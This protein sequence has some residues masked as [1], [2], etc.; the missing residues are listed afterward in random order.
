MK[1]LLDSHTH[2]LASGH[3]YCTLLEMV[4]AAADRGLELICITDHA[5][6]MELTTHKD[7][8]LNFRVIDREIYGV[9]VMMGAELN[10]MDF[11]GTVD[12][13]PK[14]LNNLD[15]AIASQ[16]IWCMPQGGGP[17]EN[18][19]AMVLAM[20]NCPKICILG[21]PDDGRYPLDY[22]ALVRAA[23]E[24]SVLLEVNNTSL[25]PACSRVNSTANVTEMLKHCRREGVPVVV[26]SDA[27]FVS[28]VG[29]HQYAQALLDELDFPEEE[30]AMELNMDA[31]GA[32]RTRRSEMNVPP[33]RKARLTV[34]TL[35]QEVFTAGIPFLKRL[36]Y[37]SEVTITGMSGAQESDKGMVTVLTHAA[38]IS[39]PMAEL[40]DL[41]KEKARME[42]ELGKSRTEL[43]KLQTKLGNPGFVNKAPANVVQAERERAEKLVTLIAGLEEQLSSMA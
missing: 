29:G 41:E 7:Y 23:G 22:P 13:S 10:V 15:M 36:A 25:S 21:H 5:P 14:L 33:S 1:F 42:K 26:G 19:A 39:M 30:K 32:V 31:I 35:E 17:E 37:G 9:R 12:L 3:A 8:F 40:V 24:R 27:H 16:H 34:A 2:T 43:E 11:D 6:G 18:T 28:A 4:R 20:D 38:R